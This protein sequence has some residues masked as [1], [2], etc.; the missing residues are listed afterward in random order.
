[1]SNQYKDLN[2]FL[3]KHNAKALEKTDGKTIIT[4]TRIGDQSLNIYGGSYVIPKE[5]LSQFMKVYYESVFVN[6]RI[7]YLTERQLDKGGGIF[8]DIDLRYK[9]EITTRQHND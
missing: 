9:H 5:E 4:H 1:M 6:K 3:A 7:E 2:E 8:I